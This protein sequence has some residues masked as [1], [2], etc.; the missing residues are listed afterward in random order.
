M[1]T[2]RFLANR[3]RELLIPHMMRKWLPHY[4][5][6]QVGVTVL[7]VVALLRIFCPDDDGL[8]MSSHPLWVF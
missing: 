4:E 6:D 5:G 8:Q 7:E 3:T 1:K 2:S